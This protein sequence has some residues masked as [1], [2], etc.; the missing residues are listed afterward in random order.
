LVTLGEIVMI[1]DLQRQGLSISAIARATGRDRKTI[2]K[3]LDR[4]LE[5]PAYRPREQRPRL[6]EPFEDYLSERVTSQVIV[7]T[8]FTG[9]LHVLSPQNRFLTGDCLVPECDGLTFDE[10]ITRKAFWDRHGTAAP[11]RGMPSDTAISNFDLGIERDLPS[12]S[13]IAQSP[14][15]M[16]TEKSK[17]DYLLT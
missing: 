13:G 11:R 2:R 3:Y 15:Q 4:G 6:L 10:P 1:H 9:R 7:Q 14:E 16:I 8:Y 17:S 12:Q 5:A